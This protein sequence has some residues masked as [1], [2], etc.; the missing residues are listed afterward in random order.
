MSQ[1]ALDVYKQ[2]RIEEIENGA[3]S[4]EFSY[5]AG[6]DTFRGIFDRA[7]D[8]A[9]NDGGNVDQKHLK[10][11]IIVAAIPVTLTKDAEIVDSYTGNTYKAHY[12]GRDDDGVPHIWLY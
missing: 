2:H 10:P 1:D 11:R 7:S 9:E 6:A 8:Q 5:N 12:F 4:R 3:F